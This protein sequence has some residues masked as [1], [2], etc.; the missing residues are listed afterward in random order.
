MRCAVITDCGPPEEGCNLVIVVCSTVPGPQLSKCPLKLT[1]I[2]VFLVCVTKGIKFK[3]KQT[4]A[5]QVISTSILGAS[6]GL[7]YC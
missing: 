4:S 6:V 3:F 7:V 5:N 2:P 1:G